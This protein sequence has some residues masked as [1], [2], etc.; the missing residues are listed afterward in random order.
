MGGVTA[1][2][3]M[4]VLEPLL[5]NLSTMLSQEFNKIKN[6][7]NQIEFLRDELLSMSAT[8]ETMSEPDEQSTQAQ[9][10]MG[11]LRDLSYEI[12]DRIETF[13]L[14]GQDNTGDGFIKKVINVITGLKKRYDIGNKINELKDRALEISDRRKRYRL[15]PSVSCPKS[16]VMDPRLPG[17]FEES[18]KLVGIDV[19][20]DKIVNLLTDGTDVHM[21]KVLSIVGYGG[22]GKTTL[23]NQ[24]L[25]KIKNKFDC[26]G[27][28]SV[29]R[30]RNVKK[31]LTD[32]LL[33]FS[34]T[35]SLFIANQNEDSA[36]MQEDLRMR[37]LEYSQLVEMNRNYLKNK[38][39]A[40]LPT[41]ID[42]LVD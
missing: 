40:I 19:Q 16:V 38:R 29:S 3:L 41:K 31:V 6:V 7:H 8:L 36:R 2:A 21:R 33:E 11:Q 18:E 35:E 9:V 27:F 13:M 1:S 22:L 39:Y 12:E 32:V 17:L 5:G 42:P 28:V 20:R 25:H 15:D 14:L 34:K 24:V 26:T 30:E 23:A 37:R 10:W 4:G